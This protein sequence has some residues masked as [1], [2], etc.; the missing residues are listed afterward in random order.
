MHID[1]IRKAGL[2]TRAVDT[3]DRDGKPAKLVTAG[4]TYA[5]SFYTGA[6]SADE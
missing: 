5:T 4:R 2:V 1:A 6:D 3:V